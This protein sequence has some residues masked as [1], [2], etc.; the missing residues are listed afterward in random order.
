MDKLQ[1]KLNCCP[2]ISEVLFLPSALFCA[3]AGMQ[4][5]RLMATEPHTP[6]RANK[7]EEM[8]CLERYSIL[9]WASGEALADWC[10]LFLFQVFCKGDLIHCAISQ[11][12]SVWR[13][14]TLLRYPLRKQTKGCFLTAMRTFNKSQYIVFFRFRQFGNDWVKSQHKTQE[15]C[16]QNVNANSVVKKCW[17][18]I[19]MKEQISSVSFID[20]SIAFC[21]ISGSGR[22]SPLFAEHKFTCK[23][24]VFISTWRW[25]T[26]LPGPSADISSSAQITMFRHANVRPNITSAVDVK[27]MP[28]L[29]FIPFL[30][31]GKA[32]SSQW[33][34]PLCLQILY[35]ACVHL[36]SNRVCIGRIQLPARVVCKRRISSI[37]LS[38]ST[39]WADGN[40]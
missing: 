34:K 23:R 13:I 9:S 11:T 25:I 26:A 33:N 19:F 6:I 18:W 7:K 38:A 24:W 39:D 31:T 15:N 5:R 22:Q 32:C 35:R 2:N 40:E 1:V 16:V 12:W 21:F 27:S 14:L 3:E 29:L 17:M 8:F 20:F 37:H 36:L 28:M 30:F 4:W 10:I